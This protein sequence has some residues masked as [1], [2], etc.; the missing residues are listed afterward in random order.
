[1]PIKEL[2]RCLQA[3]VPATVLEVSD[4]LIYRD[5]ITVGV[6]LKKLKIKEETPQ[7]R[8]CC[9]TTGFTSRSRM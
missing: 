7:G 5:F 9:R 3:D 2:M 8:S 1:M 6:L 4:S